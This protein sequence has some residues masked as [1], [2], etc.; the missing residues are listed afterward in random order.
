MG[1]ANMAEPKSKPAGALL[2]KALRPGEHITWVRAAATLLDDQLAMAIALIE[3]G[4]NRSGEPGRAPPT[5]APRA[6]W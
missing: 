5:N 1:C 6:D 2:V 3:G 4:Q